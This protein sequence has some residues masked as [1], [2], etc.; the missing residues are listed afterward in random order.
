MKPGSWPRSH[1]ADSS[2]E[3]ACSNDQEFICACD[4]SFLDVFSDDR[5]QM[6]YKSDLLV[7]MAGRSHLRSRKSDL[8]PASTIWCSAGMSRIRKRHLP[9]AAGSGRHSFPP[10]VAEAATC[11][12]LLDRHGFPIDVAEAA[13]CGLLFVFKE[14]E[15]LAA[16]PPATG[17]GV[18]G[19]PYF[20]ELEGLTAQPPATGREVG[21]VQ[22][23][24]ELERS[25]GPAPGNG[26]RGRGAGS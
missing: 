4:R 6:V 21:E 11:G 17:R 10:E 12:L 14:L 13:T 22:Y 7:A 25:G 16:P 3:T 23:F 5:A 9:Q 24:E 2:T 19:I 1:K 26:A 15:G 8:T 18:E 20:E